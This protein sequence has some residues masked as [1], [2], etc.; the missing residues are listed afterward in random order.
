MAAVLPVTHPDL[1]ASAQPPAD[2]NDFAA[3]MAQ[4]V[5]WLEQQPSASFTPDLAQLD[6]MMQSIEVK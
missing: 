6:A 3:Y 4:T 1:P 2:M 5:A